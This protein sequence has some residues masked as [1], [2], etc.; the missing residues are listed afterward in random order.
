LID[1]DENVNRI[2]FLI[3]FM[4][5]IGAAVPAAVHEKYQVSFVH[6]KLIEA[7]DFI[8]LC[9]W[10]DQKVAQVAYL[11]YCGVTGTDQDERA[12]EE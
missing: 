7:P 3:K 12:S 10:H 5:R 9:N 8:W 6:L 11:I 2:P 1:L 4:E